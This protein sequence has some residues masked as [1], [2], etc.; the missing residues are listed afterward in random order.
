MYHEICICGHVKS[1]HT[2]NCGCGKCVEFEERDLIL[3]TLDNIIS[4]KGLKP[5]YLHRP[6]VVE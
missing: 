2:P 3:R 6:I 4:G 5:E 1:C